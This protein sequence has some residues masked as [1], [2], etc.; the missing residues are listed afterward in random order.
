MHGWQANTKTHL[1]VASIPRAMPEKE[2]PP[3]KRGDIYLLIVFFF[4][5]EYLQ[6]REDDS[7]K[8]QR[9]AE[10]NKAVKRLRLF[11]VKAE[12]NHE[13]EYRHLAKSGKDRFGAEDD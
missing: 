4:Q 13:V 2:I 5:L 9:T 7:H 6:L 10:I 3:V 12:G 1:C 11:G 8:N